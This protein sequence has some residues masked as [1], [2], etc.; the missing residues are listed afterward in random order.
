MLNVS[1]APYFVRD[2][3]TGTEL[4][5]GILPI[6]TGFSSL[7]QACSLAVALHHEGIPTADGIYFFPRAYVIDAKGSVVFAPVFLTGKEPTPDIDPDISG[8]Y[9][10]KKG[11]T[12]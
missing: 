12:P 8:V 11:G 5:S 1:H 6:S 2:W 10:L 9:Y 3:E 7:T 4:I